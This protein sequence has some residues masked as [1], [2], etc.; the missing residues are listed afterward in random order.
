MP[1]RGHE[2]PA[3]VGPAAG[4]QL[5]GGLV[6]GQ[7]HHRAC[8]RRVLQHGAGAGAGAGPAGGPEGGAGGD[9]QSWLRLNLDVGVRVHPGHPLS[10]AGAS[11]RPLLL[12]IC[13]LLSLSRHLGSSSSCHFL[14]MAPLS[15]LAATCP[16][17]SGPCQPLPQV[18]DSEAGEPAGTI[19]FLPRTSVA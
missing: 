10:G 12:S 3:L 2:H 14:L 11:A 8:H 19:P 18:G 1:H 9:P 15:C 4:W 6:R 17:A 16:E 13:S 5:G 7:L